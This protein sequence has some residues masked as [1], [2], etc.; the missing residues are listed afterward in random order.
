MGKFKFILTG[1][2]KIQSCGLHFYVPGLELTFHNSYKSLSIF[3]KN[4]KAGVHGKE[5]E[6]PEG[7]DV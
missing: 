7:G 2:Y 3:T 4:M 1:L 5:R 6:T